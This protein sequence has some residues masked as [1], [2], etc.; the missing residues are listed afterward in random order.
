[1]RDMMELLEPDFMRR[2]LN[3]FVDQLA[4]DDAQ[5]LVLETLFDDY[6]G[7]YELRAGEVQDEIRAL[8][9]QMF[10]TMMS[11]Q[12][13]E[14]MGER[15]Q[16]IRT[17]MDDIAAEQGEMTRDERRDFFR[18]KMQEMQEEMQAE[19]MEQGLDLEMK[20]ALKEMFDLFEAWT[21]ERAAMRERFVGG[22]GAQLND[23]QMAAWPAFDRFLVREKSLPKSR[24][25]GKGTNLFLAID[26]FGLDDASFDRLEPLFDDYELALHQSLVSRDRYLETSA[27]RLYKALQEGDEE[28]ARDIVGRQVEYRKAVRDVNDQ[29]ITTFASE[30]REVDEER[31]NAFSQALMQRAYED[32]YRTSR[33]ERLFEAVLELE[34]EEEIR[35][36]VL[37]LFAGYLADASSMN[38]RLVNLVRK[39]EPVSLA[40]QIQRVAQMMEGNFMSAWGRGDDDDEEV[41]EAED[42]RRAM[43]EDYVSRL[44]ALLTPEQLEQ[45]PRRGRRGGSEGGGWGG[46]GGGNFDINQMPEQVR[47]RILER[48]DSD[49]DGELSESELE[50]MREQFRGGGRGGRGGRGG[51][52]GPV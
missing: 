2:D 27:P 41:D 29:F 45:L 17:E 31:G 20:S 47:E 37:E 26:E 39:Q 33:T 28:K 38:S 25:S 21:V 19:R 8:T 46:M 3:L 40:N 48:Y 42:R 18:Q 13:R 22:L 49:G 10:Q 16:Q 5:T 15:M 23:D 34:L 6:E 1:M 7:D 9:Q 12:M 51:G 32:V 52:G 11:P 36:A 24:L 43:E 44:E 30:V 14:G 4:L 50:S 35:T